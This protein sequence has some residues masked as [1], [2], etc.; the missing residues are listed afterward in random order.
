MDLLQL[1]ILLVIAGL[2]AAC[3]EFLIGYTPG[4][5]LLSVIVGVLGAYI[6]SVFRR[7]LSSIFGQPF[8]LAPVWVGDITID[9]IWTFLGS[10][11]LL[12]LIYG[13]R[14]RELFGRRF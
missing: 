6:G 3:F 9:L 1:L 11:I 13:I 4:G 2:C 7:A 8:N 12:L 14:Q 10:G 5:I